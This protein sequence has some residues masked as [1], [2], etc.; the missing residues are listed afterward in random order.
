MKKQKMKGLRVLLLTGPMI[1]LGCYKHD[2]ALKG[3][4]GPKGYSIE[5][6]QETCEKEMDPNMMC[7]QQFTEQDQFAIDCR[8]KGGQ[9]LQCACHHYLCSIKLE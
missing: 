1:F 7:T 5:G 4:S 9:A 3:H 6:K 2:D 8:E